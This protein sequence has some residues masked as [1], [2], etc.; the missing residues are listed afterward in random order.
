MVVFPRNV[1]HLFLFCSSFSFPLV[2]LLPPT[3]LL[4][5]AANRVPD[6]P[7]FLSLRCSSRLTDGI[8]LQCAFGRTHDS[9]TI[10][11]IALS[12]SLDAGRNSLQQAIS[13]GPAWKRKKVVADASNVVK[14]KMLPDQ[15]PTPRL[16][17]R[18]S[19]F[20]IVIRRSDKNTVVS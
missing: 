13:R 7:C 9:R 14:P 10:V 4:V 17:Q 18:F 11:G 3:L 2:L 6:P 1:I 12:I 8:F 16:M 20:G 19:L 5:A 15:N